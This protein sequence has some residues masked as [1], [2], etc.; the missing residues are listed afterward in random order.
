MT[1]I[2]EAEWVLRDAYEMSSAEVIDALRRLCG[3]E[4]V[5][6]GAAEAV[7]RALDYAE[8][9]GLWLADALHLAQAGECE[10]FVTFDKRLVRKAKGLINT[11]VRL[12]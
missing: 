6:V 8:R 1:V 9:G 2:L 11:P 7:G 4:R 12:G 10:A 3:L 5:K